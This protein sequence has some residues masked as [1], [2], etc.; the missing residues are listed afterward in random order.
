MKNVAS[1]TAVVLGS[2]A[3]LA[4]IVTFWAGPFAPQPAFEDV[5]IET[6]TNIRDAA[7]RSMRG[8]EAPQPQRPARDIDDILQI[9]ISALGGIAIIL[10]VVGFVRE[11]SKRPIA[12]GFVLGAGA[13]AFQFLSWFAL[14]LVGVIILAIILNSF[15]DFFSVG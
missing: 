15:G 4:A 5:L 9:V 10:A 11:E 8:E 6:A 13:I 2:V 7:V 14:V 3:L 12:A 1:L